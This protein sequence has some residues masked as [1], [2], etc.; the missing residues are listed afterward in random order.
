MGRAPSGTGG[1]YEPPGQALDA[2][3][4]AQIEA[5]DNAPGPLR[6]RVAQATRQI[7]GLVVPRAPSAAERRAARGHDPVESLLITRSKRSGAPPSTLDE[8]QY[9]VLDEFA[10]HLL[11]TDFRR[12]MAAPQ[13]R[14]FH[15]LV[16]CV[17]NQA[18]ELW[19]SDR[20]RQLRHERAAHDTAVA[21]GPTPAVDE[22][23]IAREDLASAF[24]ELARVPAALGELDRDDLLLLLLGA[25]LD[26]E[27]REISEIMGTTAEAARQR[28]H[29]LRK[30]LFARIT[31]GCARPPDPARSRGGKASVM[32][33]AARRSGGCTEREGGGNTS[34]D[35]DPPKFSGEDS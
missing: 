12:R 1:S 16:E 28:L 21:P 26:V 11:E 20:A 32:S 7:I 8:A 23:W 6:A 33:R 24:D 27:R 14:P 25:V 15:Y 2:A 17:K 31:N 9:I 22:D 13:A 3:I 30:Q 29:R 18:I 35:P 10:K 34:Q 5:I 19:R 4:R